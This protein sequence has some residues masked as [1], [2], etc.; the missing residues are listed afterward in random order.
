MNQ[1]VKKHDDITSTKQKHKQGQS[2][3]KKRPLNEKF[4]P[5]SRNQ[6]C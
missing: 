5:T 2:W 6:K 3:G 4:H 1:F